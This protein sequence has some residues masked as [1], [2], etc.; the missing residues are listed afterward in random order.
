MSETITN[1]HQ[2]QIRVY[3]EDTDAVGIVYYANYLRYAERARTELMR[4]L[5]LESSRLMR[6]EGL[7][8]AV[9][10]CHVDYLNS[11]ILDDNLVIE[12]TLRRVGGASLEATQIVRRDNNDLVR[13]ELKL[14]CIS[15]EGRAIRLPN[16]IHK[17]LTNYLKSNIS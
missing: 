8:F 13:I 16:C 15:S 3:Y 7:I 17:K 14:G 6:D 1:P 10:R 12:T 2:F 11:A 9:R 5:G 4:D